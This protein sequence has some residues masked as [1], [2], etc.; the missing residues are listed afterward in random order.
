MPF[1]TE[2]ARSSLGRVRSEDAKLDTGAL[3][4]VQL[5]RSN[6]PR[7]QPQRKRIPV[8]LPGVGEFYG[9][10]REWAS[11]EQ[12]RDVRASLWLPLERDVAVSLAPAAK[13]E[14]SVD[15]CR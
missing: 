4:E 15:L 11:W 1:S 7:G 9:P 13:R 2:L 5:A 8:A 14:N 3:G 12:N 10:R 6:L